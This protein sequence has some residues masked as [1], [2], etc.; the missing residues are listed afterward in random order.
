MKRETPPTLTVK[1]SKPKTVAVKPTASNVVPMPVP[2]TRPR[3]TARARKAPTPE[4][5][6]MRAYE[7]F[8]ARHYQH[9]HDVDD[10]LQAEIELA[11]AVKTAKRKASA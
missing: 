6:A 5:I 3:A 10:W 4:A 11:G 8:E 9:G 1:K 7:L 2:G